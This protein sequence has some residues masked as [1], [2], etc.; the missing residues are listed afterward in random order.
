MAPEACGPVYHD[1][2]LCSVCGRTQV[3]GWDEADPEE[4]ECRLWACIKEAEGGLVRCPY[5]SGFVAAERFVRYG[6]FSGGPLL[7]HHKLTSVGKQHH[8]VRVPRTTR[9]GWVT[10]HLERTVVLA[11]SVVGWTRVRDVEPECAHLIERFAWVGSGAREALVRAY[12]V[13]HFNA[14]AREEEELYER[15]AEGGRRA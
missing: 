9:P 5:G 15:F 13:A 1:R 14:P 10:R 7:P 2:D 3:A 6:Y 4:G 8:V 12:R 11:A